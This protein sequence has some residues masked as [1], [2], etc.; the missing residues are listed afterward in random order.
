MNN[1]K[2]TL[3]KYLFKWLITPFEWKHIVNEEKDNKRE[4]TRI[5]WKLQHRSIT[6]HN[7]ALT[8]A[9]EKREVEELPLAVS[10]FSPWKVNKS[11]F[12]SA[13]FQKIY[14]PTCDGSKKVDCNICNG[15]TRIRCGECRGSGRVYSQRNG[16]K[17]CPSCRES[18]TL[19][20]KNCILGKVSCSFC[21]GKGLTERWLSIEETSETV[22]LGERNLPGDRKYY[23]WPTFK[24]V[25]HHRTNEHLEVV[26]LWKGNSVTKVP[27]HLKQLVESMTPSLHREKTQVKEIL[28]QT[29]C[30]RSTHIYFSLFGK[31]GFISIDPIHN[32]I[33]PEESDLSLLKKRLVFLGSI[34]VVG[35]VVTAWIAHLYT[36]QHTFFS[37]NSTAG[38]LSFLRLPVTVASTVLAALLLLPP[39]QA[40]IQKTQ[41]ISTGILCFLV[42]IYIGALFTG[43]PSVSGASHLLQQ[44][45]VSEALLE[46]EATLMTG[47]ETAAASRLY[48]DYYIQQLDRVSSYNDTLQQYSTLQLKTE[49]GTSQA[50]EKLQKQSEREMTKLF[51]NK[52]YSQ[53][54]DYI[55][56]LPVDIKRNSDTLG[57]LY[58]ESILAIARECLTSSKYGCLQNYDKK[59]HNLNIQ[60]ELVENFQKEVISHIDD[61]VIQLVQKGTEAPDTQSSQCSTLKKVHTEVKGISSYS[62]KKVEEGLAQ[63]TLWEEEKEKQRIQEA[64]RIAKEQE[65]ARLAEEKRVEQA[66]QAEI[67]QQEIAEQAALREFWPYGRLVCRD[68]TLSPSCGCNK[69]QGCCSHHG[70]ISHC[71]R[72]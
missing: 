31:K 68:G 38:V 59:I 54:E 57:K 60:T 1:I 18:G 44:G 47:K 13:T 20:C 26:E 17:K 27:P 7:R 61:S 2:I 35:L 62:S 19:K 45:K 5:R 23:K 52:S 25:P 55:N 63:C 9:S 21:E 50:A 33:L 34:F 11:T 40:P 15:T 67:R 12:E 69:R 64:E 48:D 16:T 56:K 65:I 22:R 51:N 72:Y 14:C 30:I 8:S 36:S 71:E 6:V 39:K 29:V 43:G 42:S 46:I 28:L 37:T 66:R 58:S 41:K 4:Y 24:S 10:S 53:V 32:I 70:G 49:E 3:Q